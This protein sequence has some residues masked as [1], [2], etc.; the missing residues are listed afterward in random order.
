MEQEMIEIPKEEYEKLIKLVRY[1]QD[2][3][4]SYEACR[5]C[6]AL[7]PKGCI[8]LDCRHDNDMEDMA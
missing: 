2:W 5:N 8:C 7:H 4:P 3:C 6:G 1:V